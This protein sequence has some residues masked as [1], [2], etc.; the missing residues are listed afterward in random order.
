MTNGAVRPAP[1]APKGSGKRPTNAVK[2][3]ASREKKAWVKY[4]LSALWASEGMIFTQT[5]RI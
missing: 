2:D 5:D 1:E 3:V 4:D